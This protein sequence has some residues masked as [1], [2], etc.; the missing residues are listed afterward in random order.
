VELQ[1]T[2][3]AATESQ[4]SGFR[5]SAWGG[6]SPDTQACEALF[7]NVPIK[8]LRTGG[9]G[10]IRTLGSLST[11]RDFQSRTFDH[12]A[13]SPWCPTCA[14]ETRRHLPKRRKK[15]LPTA[16]VNA[17]FAG[18]RG[19]S[20]AA[21]GKIAPQSPICEKPRV[22]RPAKL[23]ASECSVVAYAIRVAVTS[24]L[25]RVSIFTRAGGGYRG[26][27]QTRHFR[28]V[29]HLRRTRLIPIPFSLISPNRRDANC[30]VVTATH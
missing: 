23:R 1:W 17:E 24:Q 29:L 18:Y 8:A 13:T 15:C 27:Q 19:T 22:P 5:E 10:G 6:F 14:S 30:S 28:G 26:V 21:A 4:H 25:C 11:T 2:S 12:S 9:E 7:G 20:E 3:S 16:R